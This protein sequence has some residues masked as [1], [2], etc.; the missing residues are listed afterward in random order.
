MNSQDSP[1]NQSVAPTCSM[2][3]RNVPRMNTLRAYFLLG[4][5][6]PVLWFLLLSIFHVEFKQP[7]LKHQSALSWWMYYRQRLWLVFLGDKKNI[8][9]PSSRSANE[10]LRAIEISCNITP[11]QRNHSEGIQFLQHL[12][13][14]PKFSNAYS[15]LPVFI[16]SLVFLQVETLVETFWNVKT[17]TYMTF[18]TTIRC[19][20]EQ[21]SE[22]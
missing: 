11:L 1:R 9:A 14:L 6:C 17:Q 4:R 5:C 21:R 15:S 2:L 16:L 12:G 20:R 3:S 13:K 8:P 18:N 10:P 7:T 22:V 19:C